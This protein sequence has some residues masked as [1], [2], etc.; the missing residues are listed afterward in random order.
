MCDVYVCVL[1]NKV[2]S[3]CVCVCV[4]QAFHLNMSMYL[5][6]LAPTTPWSDNT[7]VLAPRMGAGRALRSPLV[8]TW[9]QCVH[10]YTHT[11]CWRAK[12][13]VPVLVLF[14]CGSSTHGVSVCVCVFVCVCHTL[15]ATLCGAI[16]SRPA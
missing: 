14:L 4:Q 2:V 7:S 10:T 6:S 8:M 13:Y 1:V 16:M 12:L 9:T 15:F 5:P 11:G 3:V